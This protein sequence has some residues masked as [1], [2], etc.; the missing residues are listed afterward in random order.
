MYL[1]SMTLE[2][3]ISYAEVNKET[4]LE[5]ELLSRLLEVVEDLEYLEDSE[6]EA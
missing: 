6:D 1:P 4:T 5:A 2:E 3:L